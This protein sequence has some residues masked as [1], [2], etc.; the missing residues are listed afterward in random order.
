M[1]NDKELPPKIIR[2]ACFIQGKQVPSSR[3]RILGYIK[4]LESRGITCTIFPPLF[5]GKYGWVPSFA[6]G[7]LHIVFKRISQICCYF[8][9]RLFQILSADLSKFDVVL[10]QKSL[11][12]WPNSRILEKLIKSKN[13]NI[14]FDIDDAEFANI[15]NVN[16]FS[17]KYVMEISSISRVVIAG[18]EFLKGHFKKKCKEVVVLPTTVDENR[19]SPKN[20]QEEVTSCVG[21][22]GT[23]SNFRYLF[24]LTP[25]FEKLAK[26][27]NVKFL[28]ISNKNYIQELAHIPNMTFTKWNVNHEVEQLHNIDIGVMPLENDL[29]TRGKCAFKLVQYQSIGIPSV[30]SPV[31]ANKEIQKEGVTGYFAQN[32]SEWLE[33]LTELVENQKLRETVGFNARENFLSTLSIGSNVREIAK[34][35]HKLLAK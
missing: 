3:F 13:R 8:P 35:I 25:V 9:L 19:F 30:V 33:K 11:M 4:H 5:C 18:N 15:E 7:P 22:T 28:I 20:R 16:F 29:W 27:T 23:S 14:I 6:R 26:N 12:D 31:G 1:I 34:I 17:D 2:L 32:N 24:K 10:I 21:W